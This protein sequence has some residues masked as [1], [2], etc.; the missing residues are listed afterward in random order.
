MSLKHKFLIIF[1]LLSNIPIII[2]TLFTYNRYTQ[3]VDEQMAQVVNFVFKTAIDEANDSIANLNHIAE[4]FTFYSESN[5]SIIDDLKKY[6]VNDGSYT[7]YDVFKSN[8]NIKFICKNLIFS[9]NYIN[10]IFVF[11]PSGEVLGYGYGNNIDITYDYQP[12]DYQWYHDTIDLEGR[13]YVNG[14]STK[15]F[16]LNAKPSISFSRALYD[17]YTHEF[18]G[19]LF[20]DCSPAIFDLSKVNTLPDTTM[21]AIENTNT[22][23]MLYSNID[24]IK[25]EFSIKNTQTLKTTLDIP[26]LT[27]T[28]TT[29]YEKL[30]QEFNFTRILII[31]IAFI[32]AIVFIVISIFLSDSL[33]KPI[34]YL[35]T[36]MAKHK[37]HNLVTTEKYLSRTDEIGILCNEYNTMIEELNTFIKREYQNKL[38]T[39]DAQM[40]SLEAQI[41]SHFLY[42]TLESINSI[43]EI[44]EISSISTMSLSLGN[45]FRYSIKTKSELVTVS[46]ELNHVNDYLAI[47]SIRFDNRFKLIL[48]IPKKMYA[49]KVLKLILQ[50]IVENALFHGLNYCNSGSKIIIKGYTKLSSL[51]LEVSDDGVGMSS[52]QL[53]K[54]ETSLQQE[55]RFTELG[56]RNKQ[57]IGLKNIHS[58]IELYYGQG[59]GLT[60]KSTKN[61]GTTIT[62][63]LPI[64][65]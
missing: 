17:V 14:I 4:I 18:L 30:Y 44:E 52:E 63:R 9:S 7:T 23:Y 41:N 48:D 25:N 35:S 43:A 45:M 65:L 5:D 53:K 19:I 54:L 8:Q 27:L 40:K 62:L 29:N 38:I 34:I 10:G 3:L 60:L 49:S 50:P 16:I 55:A 64:I 15:D 26:I 22:N 36:K 56:H 32:C 42:N 57:S 1:L 28:S 58:R 20:I 11:T 24:S 59:Y 12:F 33:T 39:L 46:D 2:I 61:I 6:T 21:L 47:Q 31:V 37:G 51:Y 13:T